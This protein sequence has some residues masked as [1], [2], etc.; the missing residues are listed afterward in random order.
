[1]P[2]PL[3]IKAKAF[4]YPGYLNFDGTNCANGGNSSWRWWSHPSSICL[5]EWL[6]LSSVVKGN[7]VSGVGM[8]LIQPLHFT[9][10]Q[11]RQWSKSPRVTV[12]KPC[13]FPR[14]PDLRQVLFLPLGACFFPYLMPFPSRGRRLTIY[15]PTLV[16]P[17]TNQLKQYLLST[18][19]VSS[20]ILGAGVGQRTRQTKEIITNKQI[21]NS[22][23]L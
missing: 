8:V 20:T 2:E 5:L 14:P 13:L 21:I 17:L 11:M 15:I 12:A 16:L 23:F 10:G 6:R 1:M 9:D 22:D 18:Y 4:S 3:S 19:C 7:R